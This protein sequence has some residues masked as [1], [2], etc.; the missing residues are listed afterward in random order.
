M[1]IEKK[2]KSPYDF[3]HVFTRLSLDSLHNIDH[4]YKGMKVPLRIHNIPTVVYIKSTGTVK[5]PSCVIYSEDSLDEKAVME[6]LSRIF[7]FDR[8][9]K[10][11]EDHFKET[12]LAPLFK[13]FRGSPLVCEF[14]LYGCLV[15]NIIHQQVSMKVA[16]LLT[17]RFVRTFGTMIDEVFVY[18][19][20]EEIVARSIEELR[21]IGLSERKAEYILGVSKEIVSGTLSLEALQELPDEEVVKTL[22]KIRGIGPWTAQNFLMAGC[23][24]ENLFPKADLGLQNAV[25]K[26]FNLEKRPTLLQMDEL[27]E[28]W[29]PYLSYASLYL[30]KSIE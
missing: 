7:Q 28:G 12:S 23:G 16:D 2:L 4:D 27:S 17:A 19:E 25:A 9:L 24:R 18:P 29:A 22:V 6:E 3:T 14:N 26:L 20:P 1:K 8:D 10:E 13:K 30:W 21:E 5:E 11:V 15:K